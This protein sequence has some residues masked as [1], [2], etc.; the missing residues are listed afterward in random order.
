MDRNFNALSL[1][2]ARIL[3]TK[4]IKP[5]WEMDMWIVKGIKNTY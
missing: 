2:M 1:L 4:W 5:N 3:W